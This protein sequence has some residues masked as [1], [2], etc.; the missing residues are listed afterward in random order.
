MLLLREVRILPR[1]AIVEK[2]FSRDLRWSERSSFG[3]VLHKFTNPERKL[4][5]RIPPE[6]ELLR[7]EKF[8][9]RGFKF[10]HGHGRVAFPLKL[11][12]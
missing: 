8:S 9:E 2:Y 4:L 10:G 3:A 11:R 5:K 1:L 6:I 7:G 12:K